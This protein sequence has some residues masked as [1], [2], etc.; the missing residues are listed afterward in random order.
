MACVLKGHK[1]DIGLFKLWTSYGD[2]YKVW[3][4]YTTEHYVDYPPV[5]LYILY[6]VGRIAALFGVSKDE[7]AYLAFIKFVP[8]LC[9]AITTIFVFKC[10]KNKI[11]EKKAFTLAWISALNPAFLCNSTVWGQVDSFATL[12]VRLS[13]K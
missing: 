4:Y 6:T 1:N 9:D 5:Y 11:G 2:K 3:E 12:I 13:T 8:I 7:Q 10:A